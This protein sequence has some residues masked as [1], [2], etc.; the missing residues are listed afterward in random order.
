MLLLDKMKKRGKEGG[1]TTVWRS[2]HRGLPSAE[3]AEVVQEVSAANISNEKLII[4]EF[5][6]A[7]AADGWLL[8]AD[9]C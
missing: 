6:S 3:D 2:P 7:L 5:R 8:A 4:A 9:I 1:W